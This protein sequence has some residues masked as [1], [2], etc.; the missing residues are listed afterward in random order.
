MLSCR[1]EVYCSIASAPHTVLALC[2]SSLGRGTAVFYAISSCIA[3]VLCPVLAPAVISLGLVA[4]LDVGG[5]LLLLFL[6][7]TTHGINELDNKTLINLIWIPVMAGD[8]GV[9][10]LEQEPL[11]SRVELLDLTRIH[12]VQLHYL[13][14]QLEIAL[15]L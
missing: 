6:V 10:I 7:K 5:Q 11:E 15:L 8:E 14:T 4:N 9:L 13:T 3:P 2:I 1:R 12:I